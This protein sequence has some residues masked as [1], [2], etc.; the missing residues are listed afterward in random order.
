MNTISDSKLFGFRQPNDGS[1]YL[2]HIGV[3]FVAITES[4][5]AEQSMDADNGSE[6]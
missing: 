6:Q 4:E 1:V 2:A 3:L 5:K